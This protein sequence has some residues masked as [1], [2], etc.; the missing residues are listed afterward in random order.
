MRH[1]WLLITWYS[2]HKLSLIFFRV[3]LPLYASH[4]SLDLNWVDP[5]SHIEHLHYSNTS[6]WKTESLTHLPK[7]MKYHIAIFV[8][9]PWKCIFCCFSGVYRF[10]TICGSCVQPRPRWI[11]FSAYLNMHFLWHIFSWLLSQG[12]SVWW[13]IKSV[14]YHNTPCQYAV[15]VLTLP[16]LLPFLVLRQ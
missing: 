8:T 4:T 9:E 12:V 11:P 15:I 2:Y 6:K 16:Q 14:Y 7:L 3:D 5:K 13:C 1:T 10:F